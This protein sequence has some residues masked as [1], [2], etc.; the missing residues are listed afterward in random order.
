MFTSEFFFIVAGERLHGCRTRFLNIRRSDVPHTARGRWRAALPSAD[1]PS[2]DFGKSQVRGQSL[3][4]SPGRGTPWLFHR[5]A[6]SAKTGAAALMWASPVCNV[7]SIHTEPGRGAGTDRNSCAR[8]E[9][10]SVFKGLTNTPEVCFHS[11]TQEG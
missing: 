6:R 1:A 7:R 9:E 8:N 5:G 3:D 4:L 2:L 10:C 11:P